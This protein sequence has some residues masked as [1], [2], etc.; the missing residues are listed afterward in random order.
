LGCGYVP[1][2]NHRRTQIDP[3]I[4]E[5]KGLGSGGKASPL[6]IEVRKGILMNGNDEF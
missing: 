5:I 6:P 1:P 2:W 4:G 3:D